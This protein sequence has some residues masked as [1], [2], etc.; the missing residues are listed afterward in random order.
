[1]GMEECGEGAERLVREAD[2]GKGSGETGW[3]P[4]LVREVF[5]HGC[6]ARVLS[7]RYPW[8]DNSN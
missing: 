6:A 4:Q 2:Q 5:K 8:A 3:L 1:M 7:E